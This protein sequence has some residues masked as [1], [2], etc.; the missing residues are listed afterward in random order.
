MLIGKWHYETVEAAA[1]KLF[2]KGLEA[3]G[4]IGH[5]G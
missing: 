5:G 2:A 3:I 1:G 4:I